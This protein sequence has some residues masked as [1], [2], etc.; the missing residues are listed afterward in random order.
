MN[1]AAVK[2]DMRHGRAVL[3]GGEM[4]VRLARAMRRYTAEVKNVDSM[5]W[6]F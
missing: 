2:D 6:R 1:G 3:I 4:D 5:R